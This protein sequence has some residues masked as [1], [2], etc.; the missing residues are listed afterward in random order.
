V[1]RI[2]P[3]LLVCLNFIGFG[4]ATYLTVS[5]WGGEPIACA[6]V[7][8]CNFVNSSRYASV[9][10]VPISLL[11]AVLYLVMAALALLWVVLGDDRLPVLYWGTA[12]AGTG[13]ALYLTYVEVAILRA[14]CPWCVA[15]AIILAVCLVLSS[16]AVFAGKRSEPSSASA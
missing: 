2:L 12:L 7:G 13:Y 11:G 5:H 4:I 16:W 1:N 10:G 14:I 15:S 3:I 8:D 6:G 9:A